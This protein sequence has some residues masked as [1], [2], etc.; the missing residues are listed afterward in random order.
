MQTSP[1]P[2]SDLEEV[3]RLI[4]KASSA[5]MQNDYASL[6]SAGGELERL[7]CYAEAWRALAEGA[8]LR[9]DITDRIWKGP[10]DSRKI[11]HLRRLIRHVG[12]ELR[13]ARFINNALADVE[14]VIVT[15]EQRLIPLFKRTFPL[16]DFVDISDAASVLDTGCI[17]SYER[18][19]LYYGSTRSAISSTF[20]PLKA[21]P[22]SGHPSGG[23]G[24]SWYSSNKRKPLPTIEDWAS[25]LA[26]IDQPLQ[27]L[28]YDEEEAGIHKLSSLSGREISSSQPIDQI[29][30]LDG[31][32]S[33]VAAVTGVLTISNT[34]AH[35]AGALGI[36]CVV[37][38][39]D[40]QHLTWP[41]QGR[42]SP[43]YPNMI[44]VRQG[45]RPWREV[46]DEGLDLIL[47]SIK[48]QVRS[49][50]C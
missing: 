24:I 2:N 13:N 14:K 15:T 47:R 22:L 37:L 18:L 5:R 23:L 6:I 38:L 20:Q 32:A 1:I 29:A 31:F 46:I 30:D 45:G 27:S 34:T 48:L 40:C 16:A 21:R 43:F 19:A 50:S 9:A 10:Q 17:S 41:G 3:N 26:N 49:I 35:M 8:E 36:P 11:L 28:Q 44:L 33:Q 39:D 12:A 7:G 25:G 4:A 42:Q